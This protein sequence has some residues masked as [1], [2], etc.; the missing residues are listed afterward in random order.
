M[1]SPRDKIHPSYRKRTLQRDT[2]GTT[3]PEDGPQHGSLQIT[4]KANTHVQQ[5]LGRGPGQVGKGTRRRTYHRQG[6]HGHVGGG[7]LRGGARGC[8]QVLAKLLNDRINKEGHAGHH[9]LATRAITNWPS[10]TQLCD[11][12]SELTCLSSTTL[13][14]NQQLFSACPASRQPT[15]TSRAPRLSRRHPRHASTELTLGSKRSVA[16]AKLPA[17]RCSA[18]W[19][20]HSGG[21]R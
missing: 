5:H 12:R 3:V 6:P 21:H 17:H 1:G 18:R 2:Q 19:Q 7:P 13:H 10:P 4:A 14:L 16:Q 15:H 9:Q 8:S 11:L 20:D